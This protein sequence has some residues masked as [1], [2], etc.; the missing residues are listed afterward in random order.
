MDYRINSKPQ[1]YHKLDQANTFLNTARQKFLIGKVLDSD[2]EI[3]KKKS[4]HYIY[5]LSLLS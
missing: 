3:L 4:F 5:M 1:K 2:Y